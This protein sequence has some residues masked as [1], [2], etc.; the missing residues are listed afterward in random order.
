MAGVC[1]QRELLNLIVVV[2]FIENDQKVKGLFLLDAQLPGTL[3]R[4]VHLQLYKAPN[5]GQLQIQSP[6]LNVCLKAGLFYCFTS[7]HRL[8]SH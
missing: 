6:A 1:S 2:V 5:E 8:W 4:S 3:S 7:T